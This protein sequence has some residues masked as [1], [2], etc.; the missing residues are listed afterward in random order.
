[1]KPSKSKPIHVLI[2]CGGTG[3]HLYPGIAVAEV[4]K[5]RGHDVTLLI[6]E[7]KIDSLAASAHKDLRFE[8][9]PFVALP[10]IWSPKMFGFLR[11]LW[12]GRNKCRKIIRDRKIDVVL[13]MGGFTSFAPLWAG[14]TEKCRTLI[15]ESNA[16][17]GKANKL[18]A[19][20]SD[21]VLCGL[22][23][24]RQYFPKHPDVRT[25]GTPVR[26]VMRTAGKEDP[27]DF[28]KLAKDKKTLLIMGGSQGA[29]G[30]NRVVGMAL[31]QF[32]KIGIQVLHIA[33]PTDYE[34]VR[35]VY[36][37]HPML[38]Q[39]VAAFCHRMDLAYRA[40]DLAIARSGAS[41]LAE[42]GLFGTPSLL[43]PYPF[44]AEDHQT[45]N[46]EIYD[47]AGAAKMIRE[48]EINATNLTDIVREM[49][50]TNPKKAEAMGKAARKLAVPDAAER[51]A[52]LLVE[53]VATSER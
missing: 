9:M 24:C 30:V 5:A 46:A 16:I 32:E 39:H 12:A 52:K 34:E 31:D 1:M 17:P 26:S 8:Q 41:S 28:F 48:S 29:R 35:D 20:Y 6:S 44:A 49:L 13:G 11:A 4:L 10:R 40:A 38:P 21:V 33:G 22:D 50:I 27:R 19:R 7:K 18:N 53:Q 51:I 25:I 2:A 23:A 45:K 36:A 43:V 47:K 3:G 42:L 37:K 14:R 15:H